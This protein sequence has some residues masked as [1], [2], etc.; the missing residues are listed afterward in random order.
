[1]LG[2]AIATTTNKQ[3]VLVSL[4]DKGHNLDWG[5]SLEGAELDYEVIEFYQMMIEVFRTR[6]NGDGTT[7]AE[8]LVNRMHQRLNLMC[9]N[10]GAIM[11]HEVQEQY[12]CLNLI[13]EGDFGKG[14][15]YLILDKHNKPNRISR[16]IVTGPTSPSPVLNELTLVCL[17]QKEGRVDKRSG[18]ELM[19]KVTHQDKASILYRVIKSRDFLPRELNSVFTTRDLTVFYLNN[20]CQ[21]VW[22]EAVSSYEEG[23]CECYL[24]NISTN[25]SFYPEF[26]VVRMLEIKGQKGRSFFLNSNVYGMDVNITRSRD[27][28]GDYTI[29]GTVVRR[30]DY[31]Q[32]EK[33][34]YR[35]EDICG[36]GDNYGHNHVFCE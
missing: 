26:F 7:V 4:M 18:I 36:F 2:H 25:T 11:E 1:M 13:R 31:D 10:K 16:V 23:E 29:E 28:F 22:E 8:N 35:L 19:A 24:V 15:P 20:Q 34:R 5:Y 14:E 21:I 30:L 17:D 27:K 3:A 32:Q 6:F 12:Q 9:K 33:L